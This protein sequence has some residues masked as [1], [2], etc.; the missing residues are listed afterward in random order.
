[1][2][3]KCIKIRK[4]NSNKT[5][6][7]RAVQYLPTKDKISKTSAE[8]IEI[9]SITNISVLHHLIFTSLLFITSAHILSLGS[10]PAIITVK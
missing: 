3:R 1:M 6:R 10:V 4:K 2:K 9:S 5:N 7:V 8:S